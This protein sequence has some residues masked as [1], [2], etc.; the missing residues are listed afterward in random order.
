MQLVEKTAHYLDKA[1]MFE[2]I[3]QVYKVRAFFTGCLLFPQFPYYGCF[4]F[5]K[6]NAL[7]KPR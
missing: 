3:P 5:Y 1:Q 4:H 7:L 2:L 6:C